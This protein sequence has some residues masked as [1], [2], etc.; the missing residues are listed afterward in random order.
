MLLSLPSRPPESAL[1]RSLP[2]PCPGVLT[3]EAWQAPAQVQAQA[4]A[5]PLGP[6]PAQAQALAQAEKAVFGRVVCRDLPQHERLDVH[7]D[8]RPGSSKSSTRLA[9]ARHYKLRLS[10]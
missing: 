9:P 8:A 7:H 4:L 3:S 6:T 5:Q 10:A 2:W 1:R